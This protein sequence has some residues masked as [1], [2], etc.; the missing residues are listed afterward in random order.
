M[1]PK[2]DHVED[3]FDHQIASSWQIDRSGFLP[4]AGMTLS[5]TVLF[6]VEMG[7][8]KYRADARVEQAQQCGERSVHVFR[9]LGQSWARVN[10]I[11]SPLLCCDCARHDNKGAVICEEAGRNAG[12]SPLLETTESPQPL[13]WRAPLCRGA[14]GAKRW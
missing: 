10:F 1:L 12:C 11:Q 5:G 4:N 14:T 9:T 7:R 2:G 3:R 6:T 8:G 13:G